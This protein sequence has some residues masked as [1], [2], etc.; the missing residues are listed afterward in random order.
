MEES[1]VNLVSRLIINRLTF[2]FRG[3]IM[4]LRERYLQQTPQLHKLILRCHFHV[5]SKRDKLHPGQMEILIQMLEEGQCNQRKLVR[6]MGCSA[7]SVAMSIKRLEKSGYV[8]KEINPEDLRSTRIALTP[9]GRRLALESVECMK[10]MEDIQLSGFSEEEVSQMVAF[11]ERMIENMKRFLKE[12][13]VK[14]E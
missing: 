7:A 8:R 10:R 6:E 11:Q 14:G 5:M 13:R 1:E 9:V 2:I 4:N 3:K 12:E